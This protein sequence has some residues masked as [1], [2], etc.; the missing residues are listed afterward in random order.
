M[1]DMI[2]FNGQS[3][4]TPAVLT[5]VNDSAMQPISPGTGNI[6]CIMGTSTGGQPNTLLGPFASP[7]AAKKVLRSGELLTAVTKA[8]APSSALN[9]PSSIYAVNVGSNT[10]GAITL[11]DASGAAAIQLATAQY[12]TAANMARVQLLAGTSIGSM[13]VSGYAGKTIVTMD[14]VGRS[15]FTVLYS[16]AQATATITVTAQSVTLAAPAGTTVATFDLNVFSSMAQIV[17]AISGTTGFQATVSPASVNSTALNGLDPVAAL[18][19]KATATIN[20][21]LQAQIDFFNS[22]ASGGVFTASRLPTATGP[23]AATAATYATGGTAPAPLV[24]DWV[25]AFVMLQGYV[26]N[27]IAVLSPNSAVWA[28]AD[29]HVQFMSKSGSKERRAFYGPATGT[30]QAAV[31]LLPAAVNSDRGS[32]VWPGYYDYDVNGNRTLYAPYMSA[33]IVAAGFASLNPGQTMTEVTLNVLGLETQVNVP[34]STDVLIPAGVCVLAQND[35]GLPYVVRAISTWLADNK[36]DRVE[37]SCGAAVDFTNQTVR[38]ALKVALG[39]AGAQGQGV[40]P[41]TMAKLLS[42][43]ETALNYCAL[44]PPKGPGALVGDSNSPPWTSLTAT[45]SGDS[46]SISFQCSPVI[47]LNF[48]PV[49]NSIVPYSGTVTVNLPASGSLSGSSSSLS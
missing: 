20:A 42:T 16:G 3:T 49:T 33:A 47:P 19:C 37:V 40:S 8:F 26:V 34:T 14:N 38:A 36:F 13:I 15:A 32:I 23:A 6:L 43:A 7:D 2:L 35:A 27:W 9:A 44:P 41:I 12:G 17:D 39:S 30:S 5:A 28:A 21:N 24:G 29:A 46:I 25:S 11:K 31:A 22:T 10:P 48:I 4:F 1:A 45:A 18:S